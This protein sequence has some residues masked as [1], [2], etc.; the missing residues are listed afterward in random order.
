MTRAPKVIGSAVAAAAAVYGGYVA[1]TY[2]RF[3]RSSGHAAG[4]PLLDR[5]MP[6]HEVRERHSVRVAAPAEIT[7]A[8]ARDVSFRDSR[9]ARIIFALRELPVRLVGSLPAITERRSILDEVTA[10]GWRELAMAPGRQIMGAVTQPW[11]PE[12]HFRGLSPDEFVRFRDPGY[13]KIA[14]TIEVDPAGNSASVFSTETRVMTTDPAS[15]ERFRRYWAVVSPGIRII[16]YEILR[17]VR[18]EAE[19]RFA[20]HGSAAGEGGRLAPQ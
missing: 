6:E 18:T 4:S 11:K 5:F 14:W 20:L 8:A 15:H 2:L 16:R 13:A 12:V 9:V 1:L 7:S 19:R 17:L 10:L 3:G